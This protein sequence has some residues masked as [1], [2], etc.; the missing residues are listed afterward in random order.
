MLHDIALLSPMIILLFGALFTLVVD[1]FL[2]TATPRRFWGPF[3]ALIS[4]AAVL[5]TAALWVSGN[6]E[7]QTPAFAAHLSASRLS[8]FFTALTAVCALLTHLSSPAFMDEQDHGFGEFYALLHFAA[9]GMAVMVAA[10]SL[11]TLFI[12]LEIMSLSVYVLAA[13]KRTSLASVEAGL[14]YFIMGSVAS[15]MLLYGMAFLYGIAGGTTYV[16][17]QRALVV[18]KPGLDLWL[19]LAVVLTMGAFLFKVAAVPFH[20]WAPDA[21]EGAPT[22]VAGFMSAGVKAA[23]FG[24]LLKVLYAALA[25]G[26]I[27]SLHLSMPKMLATFA[28]VTMTVGNI[29]ALRQTNAKRILGFSAI[30]HA[31]YLLLGCVA[32][33]PDGGLGDHYHV[34]GAA[35]PFYLVGYALASL[36]VFAALSVVGKGG[37]ELT[38]QAQLAGLGRRYPLAGAVL[39][40]GLLSLAGVPPTLGF[41]GKL[42]LLHE[43]LRAGDQYVPHAVLLVL[44]SVVAAY[45]YLRI[46]VWVYMKPEGKV[47]REYIRDR[48]LTWSMSLAALAILCV[49]ILPSRLMRMAAFAG[50]AVR[51]Q[52]ARA[53]LDHQLE[54]AGLKPPVVKAAAT[55]AVLPR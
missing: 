49:G 24:A 41:F 21:Y 13:F 27:D 34:A 42:E 45:Y 1:P 30:A 22:P 55:E 2:P 37:Q 53:H 44:N 35:V 7:M 36:A 48:S 12:G 31:G 18:P 11:I 51:P 16:E 5:A 10:E 26:A 43:V 38:G 40:L 33:V 23:A 3:G 9:F 4:G 19:G 46:T 20:M 39:T 32:W 25:G 50:G 6:H 52:V 54:V 14:K 8:L 28:V 15:A 47:E 29:A 17:I